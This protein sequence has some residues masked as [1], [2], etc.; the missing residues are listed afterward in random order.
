MRCHIA[1]LDVNYDVTGAGT[2]L[3]LVHGAG[4]DLLTWDE[5]VPQLA[6]DFRVWRMDQRGFGKTVRPPTPRLS[7]NAWTDDLLAFMDALQI[8]KAALVGWSMGGAVVLNFT[9]LYPERVSHL[10]PIGAPG[11]HQ[12]VF[13]TSGFEARQRMADAGYTVEEIV[14]ATFGFTL[15]A[16]SQ[17]SREHNPRA[18]E[19][20]RQTLLRNDARDYAEMVSSLGGLA[21]F[22]P[23][24][25]QIRVPTLVL[26]GAEDSRTP[27]ALSEAL[28]K[29]I[30]GSS[31]EIIPDCGHYYGFEKPTVISRLIAEFVR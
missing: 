27:P 20:M 12:V 28:H 4:A 30:R 19:S 31:L 8:E 18:V 29:A 13:D 6:S 23:R 10:V 11:P 9:T 1:D 5:V 26:C 14:A 16:F 15:A 24:L 17:W 3:L 2:P 25:D 7:L 22:G 21:G